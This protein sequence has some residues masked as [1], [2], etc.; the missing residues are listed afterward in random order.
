VRFRFICVLFFAKVSGFSLV[1]WGTL[2]AVP[3]TVPVSEH[4]RQRQKADP[5]DRTTAA[6]SPGH[7]ARSRGSGSNEGGHVHVAPYACRTNS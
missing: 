5:L 6:C 3:D 4:D 7:D 2:M 1:I